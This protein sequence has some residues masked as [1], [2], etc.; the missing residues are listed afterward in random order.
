VAAA[1]FILIGVSRVESKQ[2]HILTGMKSLIDIA[3]FMTRNCFRL[4][5]SAIVLLLVPISA[6]AQ[7]EADYDAVEPIHQTAEAQIAIKWGASIE[8]ATGGG[9]RG[10]WRQN[11]SNYNYVDD[12]TIALDAD[13]NAAV[14]WVDQQQK[15][16]FFQVYDRNGKP[17]QKKPVNVSRTPKVF[18]WLPRVVISPAQPGDLCILWQEIVFS[19]GSHGGEIFF[20]R[21][22]NGGASFGEPLNLSNSIHGDGKGRINKD[23]WHNGSL[24]L[25]IGPDGTLYAAW[26]EYDGPLSFSRSNDRGESFSTPARIT[27]G[28]DAKPARAPALAVGSDN[29]V[30]LTWTVGEDDGA[31]IRL[32]KSTDRGRTFGDAAMVA[33]TR[34]Y[35]D[36]PKVAVDRK[37]IVHVTHA[38]SSGGPFDRYH[39][40]YAR[41]RDGARTF[42]PVREISR[43]HP[44]SIDSAA[45]PALSLDEQDNIYVLWEL[46]PDWRDQPRGLAIAC[47]RDGGE[48][49]TAPAIV[50]GSS[51]A[52]GGSNGSHQGL[53]M[54][55]LAV[56]RTGAVAV[57]NCSLKHNEKSRVWLMRGQ[58]QGR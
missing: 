28:G 53:L 7:T 43:P 13:G 45:F 24:D 17:R 2:A 47:S 42:E 55:K 20:A 3:R 30:Y 31:D 22:R 25:V 21:S 29:V 39:I 51:D 54:R 11:E 19:G 38:E 46:Y 6:I 32:A 44:P 34:A 37:G 8:I 10:P 57:V 36:A 35:S 15:D 18:S 52:G 26:T 49:F 9:Q 16:V 41:S 27:G 48:T 4:H 23:I 58:L 50:P 1:D 5:Q 12:S 33:K 56:N 14:A 40:H